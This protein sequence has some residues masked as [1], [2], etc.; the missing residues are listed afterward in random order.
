[1]PTRIPILL[2]ALVLGGCS[3]RVPSTDL[4]LSK[5]SFQV[6]V[7]A[8]SASEAEVLVSIRPGQRVHLVAQR[9]EM[10]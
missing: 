2:L 7:L 3:H 4:P 1:M 5:M 6:T 9:V 8:R 10:A